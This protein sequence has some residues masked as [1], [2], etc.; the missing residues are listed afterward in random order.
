M[1]MCC[2]VLFHCS[3]NEQRRNKRKAYCGEISYQALMINSSKMRKRIEKYMRHRQKEHEPNNGKSR[4][5]YHKMVQ[6][7]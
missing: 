3:T 5:K 6:I 2:S 4:Q 7:C 1:K